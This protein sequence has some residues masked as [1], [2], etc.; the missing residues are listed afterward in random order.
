[1]KQCIIVR[2]DL[3]MEPGKTASQVSH[4]SVEA[5]FNSDRKNVEKW[6]H[7]GMTKII[8]KVYSK[9]ELIKLKEKAE[10]I[11][12][13]AVLITDAGHTAFNGVPTIT[14][15]GIGPDEDEK[16]DKVAKELKLL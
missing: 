5:A 8:L 3:K 14:A 2:K 16:I 7:E 4:A 13:V 12:M 15:L 10:K 6:R 11:G 1:M 9:E